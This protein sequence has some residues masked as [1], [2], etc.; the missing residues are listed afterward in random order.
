M[1]LSSKYVFNYN[2]FILFRFPVRR[3]RM[4]LDPPTGCTYAS[5]KSTSTV[6]LESL[7]LRLS[8]VKSALSSE[9]KVLKCERVTP[10]MAVNS[11][12]LDQSVA[13]VVVRS[14]RYMKELPELIKAGFSAWKSSSPSYEVV[15]GMFLLVELLI[16]KPFINYLILSVYLLIRQV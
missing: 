13:Y 16:T 15:Q 10:V 11:S 2:I 1:H 8:N 14:R 12:F 5:F 3:V 9:R 7:Q 6:K 4:G